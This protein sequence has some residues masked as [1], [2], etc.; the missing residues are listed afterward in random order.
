MSQAAAHPVHSIRRLLLS[1][2]LLWPVWCG[3]LE[4]LPD[5]ADRDRLLAGEVV[6]EQ[7]EEGSRRAVATVSALVR[8]PV[9]DVWA[10]IVSCDQARVFVSGLRECEVRE[11][12]GTYA[13]THQV[14]D[15]GWF[16]PRLDYS[17]ETRRVP[18][19]RMDFDLL[20][21]NLRE[22]SGF[23]TFER[24]AEGLLVRHRLALAPQVPAPR[25]LVRR[26]IA[27]DLPDMLQCIRVLSGGSFDP[28][29]AAADRKA[30]AVA[31][32]PQ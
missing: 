5:S 17:F 11:D 31:P 19:T 21:G 2:F 1:L 15:K 8:A 6:L 24:F 25:W 28:A 32:A 12:S 18:H 26:S 30:C 22:M 29:Q 13:V 10:V 27:R 23:W 16:T 14:V 9:E 20:E 4:S 7:R 3:A